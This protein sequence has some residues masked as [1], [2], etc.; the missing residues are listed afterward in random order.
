MGRSQVQREIDAE[1]ARR[2]DADAMWFGWLTAILAAA[3]VLLL[4]A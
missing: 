1:S 2:A 3:A 4:T